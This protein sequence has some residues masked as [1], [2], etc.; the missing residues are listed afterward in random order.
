LHNLIDQQ[1]NPFAGGQQPL[2]TFSDRSREKDIDPFGFGQ[3][4]LSLVKSKEGVGLKDQCNCHMQNI[5][6]ARTNN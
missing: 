3:L 5:K 6:R 2:L 1:A 4:L